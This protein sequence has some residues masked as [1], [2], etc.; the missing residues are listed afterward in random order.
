MKA[1]KLS[2]KQYVLI[3]LTAA[4]LLVPVGSTF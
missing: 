3:G 1:Q 2:A 4:T